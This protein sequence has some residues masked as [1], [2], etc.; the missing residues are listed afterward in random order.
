M[1]QSRTQYLGKSG[2]GVIGN[3]PKLALELNVQIL[4]EAK[5]FGAFIHRSSVFC[6]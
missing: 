5:E 4:G 3:W 6:I 2:S 1:Y